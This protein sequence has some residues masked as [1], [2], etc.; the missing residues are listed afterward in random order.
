MGT[1]TFT[2]EDLYAEIA[3]MRGV[4]TPCK[5][6]SGLGTKTYGSTSTWHGGVGGQTITGGVCDKCW[7]SG[8][9][10]VKWPSHRIMQGVKDAQDAIR[11]A[12]ESENEGCAQM[13][14]VGPGY[15]SRERAAQIRARGKRK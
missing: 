5:D 8:D 14:E 15:D 7:G 2:T 9:A 13:V 4:E 12:R 11:Q 3:A 10:H 6:C 1:H